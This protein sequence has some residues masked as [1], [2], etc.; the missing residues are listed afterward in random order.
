MSSALVSSLLVWRL[1][2]NEKLLDHSGRARVR[3]G[4]LEVAL[5]MMREEMEA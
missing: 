2:S 3:Y 5:K 1:I 4:A